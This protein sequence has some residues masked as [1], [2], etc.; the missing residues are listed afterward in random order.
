MLRG[1]LVLRGIA[2][3][4]VAADKAQAQMH[5]PVAKLDAFFANELPGF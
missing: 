4:D 5:P 3:A 1:V 2:T